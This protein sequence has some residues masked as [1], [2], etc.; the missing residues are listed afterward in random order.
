M[1]SISNNGS[2]LEQQVKNI[3]LKKVPKNEEAKPLQVQR[4]C[5]NEQL[6]K[7]TVK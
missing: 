4:V 3:V 7:V 1:S 2:N 6:K 5:N